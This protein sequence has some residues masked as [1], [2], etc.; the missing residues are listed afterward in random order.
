MP[1]IVLITILF[2]SCVSCFGQDDND[3][4]IACYAYPKTTESYKKKL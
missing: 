1:R 3:D 4:R 2:L